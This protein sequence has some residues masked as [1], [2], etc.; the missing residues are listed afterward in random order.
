[1]MA[2]ARVGPCID[3]LYGWP[4]RYTYWGGKTWLTGK[5]LATRE[6]I[7][8]VVRRREPVGVWQC[9][10]EGGNDCAYRDVVVFEF[11]AKGCDGALK[12]IGE[13]YGETLRKVAKILSQY[14][15]LVWWNGNKSIYWAVPIKPVEASYVP[16]PEWVEFVKVMG[17]D[18]SMLT[19]KHSFRLPC[20]PHQVTGRVSTWLDPST[21]KPT[22]TPQLRD[23][24]ESPFTFLEPPPPPKPKRVAVSQ[25]RSGG[26]GFNVLEA[27]RELVESSP[28]LQK[29]CR[30]RL[31][32]FIGGMCATLE[33]PVE[34]CLEY[35][36]SLPVEWA[37]EHERLMA[38]YYG[39]VKE[40]KSK[41]SFKS[42]VEGGK[43]YSVV[44]CL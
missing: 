18:S 4:R 28:K 38:Y 23:E 19:P 35:M 43:W 5:L 24:R 3:M 22:K 33:K 37:K 10:A 21:L 16:R 34:E 15:P 39:R 11:D 40:G 31:A 9:Y 6:D 17:M 29:D 14:K 26:E 36:R 12:C 42:L 41:F 20:T 13:R 30:K 44:E 32:A 27:V 7:E 2:V 1:M 8:R 25:R